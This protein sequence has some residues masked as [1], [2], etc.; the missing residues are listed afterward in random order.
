MAKRIWSTKFN[1]LVIGARKLVRKMV[2]PR[3]SQRDQ[4]IKDA[5]AKI[6]ERE[7]RRKEG[8][9]VPLFTA[10][11]V[12]RARAMRERARFLEATRRYARKRKA[13]IEDM[14]EKKIGIAWLFEEKTEV[15]ERKTEPTEEPPLEWFRKGSDIFK[16]EGFTAYV[17]SIVE[18]AMGKNPGI[19]EKKLFYKITAL[20]GARL[21]TPNDGRVMVS[22]ELNQNIPLLTSIVH[23]SITQGPKAAEKVL[24]GIIKD[25]E[26]RGLPRTIIRYTQERGD[27]LLEAVREERKRKDFTP[28]DMI[29]GELDLSKMLP[30]R[31]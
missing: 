16:S 22:E 2:S 4:Y 3:V 30:E 26:N 28:E 18:A 19:K 29:S 27:A 23:T 9:E 31:L 21:T 12:K 15:K 24:G 17:N 5:K 20:I 10:E 8:I 14:S 6:A 25:M 7:R 1:K 11:E 13:D